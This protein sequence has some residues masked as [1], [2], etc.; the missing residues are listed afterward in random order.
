MTDDL[1]YYQ[2]NEKTAYRVI[3]IDSVIPYNGLT[4]KEKNR[5][6]KTHGFSIFREYSYSIYVDGSLSI[7]GRV[8]ELIHK[9]GKYGLA[10]YSHPYAKDP[11]MEALSQT[12]CSRITRDEANSTI[13]NF[14]LAGLPR[15]C[16][17]VEGGVVIVDNRNRKAKDILDSWFKE[18]MKGEAKRDQLY[19]PYVL[20]KKQID[21]RDLNTIHDNLRYNGYFRM[22]RFH[23][24]YQK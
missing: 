21:I 13:N 14:A 23:N 11:Y 2:K 24:G 17:C 12:L 15:R 3:N 8:S 1:D 18:Y 9:I 5:Y 19:L 6:C 7:V 16:G 10:F 22:E 20:Y 4:D